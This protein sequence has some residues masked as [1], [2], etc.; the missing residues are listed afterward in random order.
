MN[1]YQTG[2]KILPTAQYA[3]IKYD[4]GTKHIYPHFV[5][6]SKLDLKKDIS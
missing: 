1:K 3:S 2:N 4:Q 5:W 6:D